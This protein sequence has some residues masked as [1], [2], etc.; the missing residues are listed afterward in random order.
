MAH[1]AAG[2][3]EPSGQGDEGSEAL[4]HL[5]PWEYVLFA[6]GTKQISPLQRG[7]KIHM[8]KKNIFSNR[9]ISRKELFIHLKYR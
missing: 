7:C 1:R 4:R 8:E 5:R 3:Q 6:R 9:Y 2:G